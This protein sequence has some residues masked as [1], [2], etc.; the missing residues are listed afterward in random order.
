[1]EAKIK[2][3]VFN[4]SVELFLIKA[5][6]TVE[7]LLETTKLSL[8]SLFTLEEQ[9]ANLTCIDAQN[10]LTEATDAAV[11]LVSRPIVIG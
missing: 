6:D 11:A 4:Q 2:P 9:Y 5:D 7:N 3:Y 8:Y 1:M 10:L